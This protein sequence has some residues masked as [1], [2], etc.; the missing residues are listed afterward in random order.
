M[1]T[2]RRTPHPP[3]CPF[4]GQGLP[5]LMLGF[6]DHVELSSF[7]RAWWGEWRENVKREA[8]GT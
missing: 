1:R 7:C 6:L 2:F 4:C 3:A 8:G 5:D